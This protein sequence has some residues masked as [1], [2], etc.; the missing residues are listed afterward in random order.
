MCPNEVIKDYFEDMKY[1]DDINNCIE[2]PMM[3]LKMDYWQKLNKIYISYHYVLVVRP[4]E[5]FLFFK[6]QCFFK[7]QQKTY[8]L[9][10]KALLFGTNL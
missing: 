6:I 3:L 1:A 5:K 4:S 8:W 7:L 9:M 2:T 10:A